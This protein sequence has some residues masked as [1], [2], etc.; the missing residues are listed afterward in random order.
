M[1]PLRA[2]QAAV[3]AVRFALYRRSIVVGNPHFVSQIPLESSGCGSGDQPGSVS[4][5]HPAHVA[6]THSIV[7]NRSQFSCAGLFNEANASSHLS[8]NSLT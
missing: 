5:G 1:V 8:R 2:Q 6:S 7:E 4:L 3:K